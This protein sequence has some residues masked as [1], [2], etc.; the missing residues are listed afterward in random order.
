[1]KMSEIFMIIEFLMC[2]IFVQHS[3]IFYAIE[4]CYMI[5]MSIWITMD[6]MRSAYAY[7]SSFAS[8]FLS[9]YDI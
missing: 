6:H 9:H 3:N 4:I 5:D 1:M 2:S 7:V 8:I